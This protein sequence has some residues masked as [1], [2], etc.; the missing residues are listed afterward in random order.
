MITIREH[1]SREKVENYGRPIMHN[2][3]ILV[4]IMVGERHSKS[5]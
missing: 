2:I 3:I 4:Q 1:S 5:I